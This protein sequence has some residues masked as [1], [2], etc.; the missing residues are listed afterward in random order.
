MRDPDGFSTRLFPEARRRKRKIP[1][2]RRIHHWARNNT[3]K[4]S[5]FVGL[6]LA[7][8][9]SHIYWYNKLTDLEYN[10][11]AAWAQVEAEQERRYHIQQDLTRLVVAYA[12]HERGL[13]TELTQL[14][15]DAWRAGVPTGAG[16]VAAQAPAPVVDEST[17]SGDD[18]KARLADL[19]PQ[20]LDRVFPQILLAAEQYPNLRLTENFQQFSTAIIETETRISE[21]IQIYN[22]AVNMYTTT[23]KQFPGNIFG[24][25][26]GFDMYE[27]YVP[28]REGLEFRPIA[29]GALDNARTGDGSQR[30][31]SERDNGPRR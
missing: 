27:F 28:K 25:V 8:M 23:L 13:M 6:F 3:W 16:G 1:L 21:H 11:Q 14:R 19:P 22:E 20:D 15:T 17:A 18:T 9:I 7:W 26:W 5:F 29:Y 10:I 4:L 12:Q 31:G 24:A 30:L 2:G